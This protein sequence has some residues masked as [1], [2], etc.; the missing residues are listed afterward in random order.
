[1][2]TFCPIFEGL[3]AVINV[4]T[5]SGIESLLLAGSNRASKLWVSGPV[6]I[7]AGENCGCRGLMSTFHSPG[8]MIVGTSSAGVVLAASQTGGA[9]L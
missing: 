7:H 1:M 9:Q 6:T 8:V 4:G 2:S 3:A 5:F